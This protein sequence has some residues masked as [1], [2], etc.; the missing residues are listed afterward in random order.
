M[1]YNLLNVGLFSCCCVFVV[2]LLIC[3][4]FRLIVLCVVCP[5]VVYLWSLLFCLL[6]CWFGFYAGVVVI[7]CL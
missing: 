2:W 6:L 4:L 1:L 5:Q 7:W 3:L